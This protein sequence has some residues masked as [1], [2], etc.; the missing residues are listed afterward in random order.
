M[1]AFILRFKSYSSRITNSIA[2]YPAIYSVFAVVLS[3]VM[4][5]LERQG[6]S[7][8]LKENIALFVV[9]NE[10]TARSILTTLIAGCFSLL[11]FSFSMVMLLLNQAANN[12]SPR[13]L[14][15]LIANKKHQFILGIFLSSILFNII[16]VVSIEPEQN[17]YAVPGFSVLL[18]I[19]SAIM[20][21][22]A[23]V[24]FIHSISTSIQINKI[25]HAIFETT[26]RALQESTDYEAAIDQNIGF[27]TALW[28]TYEVAKIGKIQNISRDSLIK[29]CVSLKIR[30]HILVPKGQYLFKNESLYSASRV[31]TKEER[32]QVASSIIFDESER[33]E[34]NFELGF[35]QLTEV[36]V[37]AMSPGINDPG[38]AI[39]TLNYLATLA[40][41]RM[42]K[43]DH[44]FFVNETG[45]LVAKTKQLSFD[46]LMYHT[47]ASYRTYCKH[48]FNM[49]HRLLA[50]LGQ[51]KNAT[52]V[53][54]T[55]HK[56]INEQ[57]ALV[58]KDATSSIPNATDCVRLEQL[59]KHIQHES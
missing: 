52:A 7:L 36:G 56:T 2:F 4:I 58:F 29:T 55:Y 5:W 23:F 38:T 18:G 48:D 9:S 49:S 19:T 51:L 12:F 47:Y 30:V 53:D 34:E 25:M 8:Y 3:M 13:V 42:L 10:D 46:T 50:T 57:L 22:I 39:E 1:Q 41:M 40:A 17:A 14:P 32:E 15:G 45:D 16:T 20:A 33:V 43:K 6:I 24:Y 11:V 26:E 54:P 27:E 37:K 35:K 21:L 31:L 44:T 59:Y 28:P